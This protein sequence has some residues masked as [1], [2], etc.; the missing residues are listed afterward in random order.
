M[1][2]NGRFTGNVKLKSGNVLYWEQMLTA[3]RGAT[4]ATFAHDP[5]EEDKREG[6]EFIRRR[7]PADVDIGRL[8]QFETS[9]EVAAKIVYDHL[10]HHA[11]DN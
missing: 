7:R 9:R 8:N 6:W 2:S 11:G 5:S 4:H 1:S 10:T 3:G